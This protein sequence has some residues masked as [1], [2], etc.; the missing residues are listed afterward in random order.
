MK[1]LL[2]ILILSAVSFLSAIPAAFAGGPNFLPEP[3]TLGLVAIGAVALLVS[4]F[5]KPK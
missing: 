5:R 3:E 2:Q 4:R 1:S